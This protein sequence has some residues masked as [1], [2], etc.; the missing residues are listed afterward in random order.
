MSYFCPYCGK[1]L[2]ESK[3]LPVCTC[4]EFMVRAENARYRKLLERIAGMC[5][6]PDAAQACRNILKLIAESAQ[7]RKDD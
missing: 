7:E 1:D 3:T 2:G 5:G 4:S 6:A